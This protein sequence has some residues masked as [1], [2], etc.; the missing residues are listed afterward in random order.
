MI[1]GKILYMYIKAHVNSSHIVDCILMLYFVY[2]Y[3]MS[4]NGIISGLDIPIRLEFIEVGS[5][6]L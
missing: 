2:D 4:G 3:I 1:A 6:P 5:I